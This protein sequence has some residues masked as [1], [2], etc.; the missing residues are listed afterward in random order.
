MTRKYFFRTLLQSSGESSKLRLRI[1]SEK[2]EE[3]ERARRERENSGSA[4][5]WFIPS[6]ENALYRHTS[7][8]L[9]AGAGGEGGEEV[10][11]ESEELS[12]AS[13]PGG[14]S[15]IQQYQVKLAPALGNYFLCSNCV[16]C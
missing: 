6:N 2:D 3:E 4:L 15:L 10:E 7:L 8:P 12:R 11:D 1:R 9:G 14:L 13:S 5:S 16:I